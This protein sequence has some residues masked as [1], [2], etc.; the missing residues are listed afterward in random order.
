MSMG[1]DR[2]GC[3]ATGNLLP[4]GLSGT[5]ELDFSWAEA[6][7]LRS[8]LEAV[9]STVISSSH[10]VDSESHCKEVSRKVFDSHTHSRYEP[11]RL[12]ESLQHAGEERVQG[13]QEAWLA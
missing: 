8:I 6:R 3:Y 12:I 7:R 4:N 11:H 9:L 1:H 5:K 10:Q 2:S 13:R